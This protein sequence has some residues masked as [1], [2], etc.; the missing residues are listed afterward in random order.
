MKKI[1]LVSLA[2]LVLVL[3][4]ATVSA[5]LFD[6]F[7]EDSS[8][9]DENGVI[10]IECD[11]DS[12][13]GTLVIHEFKNIK[14]DNNTT[15]INASEFYD[16]EGYLKGGIQ[17]SIKIKDGKAEYQLH[18]DTEFFSVDYFIANIN[19]ETAESLITVEYLFNG[20]TML[21]SSENN[22]GIDICPVSF[23]DT[24]YSVNG[25]EPELN[26]DIESGEVYN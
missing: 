2:L 13:S 5:G 26:M 14:Q 7:G 16:D 22:G 6:G 8:I 19:P 18:N 10:K 3:S 12:I 23:G 21:S 15:T 17:N 4:A 25:T 24:I 20:Q 9:S 1:F 11:N